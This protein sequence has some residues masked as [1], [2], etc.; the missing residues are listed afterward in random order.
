ML[1]KQIGFA[2]SLRER[3]ARFDRLTGHVI[4][5]RESPVRVSFDVCVNI[6]HS[7]I[8]QKIVWIVNDFVW[9]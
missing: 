5:Y 1:A 9:K 4:E 7:S 8:V 6:L 3:R 2:P